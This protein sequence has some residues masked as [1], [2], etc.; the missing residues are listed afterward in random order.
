MKLFDECEYVIDKS[1]VV[2]FGD[3]S[4]RCLCLDYEKLQL[5]GINVEGFTVTPGYN[6]F[7]EQCNEEN[8]ENKLKQTRKT[9]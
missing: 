9:Q 4:I 6:W 7:H 1:R 8:K 5:S 3:D 2:K